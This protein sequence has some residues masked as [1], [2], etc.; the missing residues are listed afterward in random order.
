[1]ERSSS[2]L[3]TWPLSLI[4][5]GD[6]QIL[7]NM[8][9]QII[10]GT[11]VHKLS[12][13]WRLVARLQ[14]IEQWLA[15]NREITFKHIKRAGNKVADL[16]ANLGVDNYRTLYSGSLDII[17][18]DTHRQDYIALVKNDAAPSDAGGW[19]WVNAD[20]MLVW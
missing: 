3:A 11:P 20:V 14:H 12:C 17:K 9:S 15:T 10:W 2:S 5:E 18:N 19:N 7:I 6:S 8:A 1:M 16:L 4:I 13:S